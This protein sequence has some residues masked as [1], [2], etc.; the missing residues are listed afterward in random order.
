MYFL[1]DFEPMWIFSKELTHSHKKASSTQ[2]CRLGWDMLVLRRERFSVLG[3][4]GVGPNPYK[5]WS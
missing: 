5:V 2:E 4:G 1:F 3:I